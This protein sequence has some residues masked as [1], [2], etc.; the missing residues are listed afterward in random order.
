MTPADAELFLIPNLLLFAELTAARHCP[1]AT[2]AVA[3]GTNSVQLPC[4]SGEYALQTG[5]WTRDVDGAEL[6]GPWV[7]V[8]EDVA[9]DC[10]EMRDV[11]FASGGLPDIPEISKK[12]WS[13]DRRTGPYAASRCLLNAGSISSDVNSPS[14]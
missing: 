2:V 11:R 4:Q 3:E 10:L 12:R 14:T 6:S 7:Y 5:Q 9:M 8:L 1:R 13:R